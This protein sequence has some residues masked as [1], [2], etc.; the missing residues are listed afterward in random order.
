MPKTCPYC[1]QEYKMV[2]EGKFRRMDCNHLLDCPYH[3]VNQTKNVV[4][5]LKKFSDDVLDIM[6]S[7]DDE[8]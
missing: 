6:G 8:R 4:N 7:V 1:K 2:K 5:A 3:L